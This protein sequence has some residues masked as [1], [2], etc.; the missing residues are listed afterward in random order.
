VNPS[1]ETGNVVAAVAIIMQ[2]TTTGL[3]CGAAEKR[4]VDQLTY[5]DLVWTKL[6]NHELIF[7][8]YRR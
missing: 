5:S 2:E 4:S 3:A 6:L 7:E 8:T 1:I